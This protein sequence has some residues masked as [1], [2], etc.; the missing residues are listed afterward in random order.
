MIARQ[1]IGMNERAQG[2]IL[3]RVFEYLTFKTG[4]FSFRN[5]N[6]KAKLPYFPPARRVLSRSEANLTGEVARE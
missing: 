4:P 5:R 2:N 6:L 1:T 3:N